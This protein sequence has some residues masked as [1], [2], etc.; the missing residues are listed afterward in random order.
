MY[1]DNLYILARSRPQ[2]RITL[3]TA[4]TLKKWECQVW[5]AIKM[6]RVVTWVTEREET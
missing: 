1:E 4:G 3:V 6:Y 2:H 5:R